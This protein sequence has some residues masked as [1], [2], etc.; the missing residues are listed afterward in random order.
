M[1][2]RNNTVAK[3]VRKFRDVNQTNDFHS[4]W[5]RLEASGKHD[6]N[7]IKEAMAILAFNNGPMPPEWKDHEL[8][9]KYQGFRECH[10]KGDLLI[11]Y[12][13]KKYPKTELLNFMR[14]G[15][16]SELFG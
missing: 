16:H 11:M 3:R 4:D 15:T 14:I 1:I 12:E 2:S 10:V 13:I 5:K 9:G 6:M 8:S 7:R